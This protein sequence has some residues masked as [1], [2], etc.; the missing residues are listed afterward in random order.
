[1]IQLLHPVG[2]PSSCVLFTRWGRVGEGGQ[3][4][5]KGP[6]DANTAVAQFKAQFKNK[7]GTDWDKRHGMVAKKG[8]RSR[9]IHT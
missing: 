7:T 2:N 1:M 4:Q 8:E 9:S 5:K 6:W 3:Q